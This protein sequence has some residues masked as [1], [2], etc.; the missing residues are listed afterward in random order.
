MNDPSPSKTNVII[1]EV[2]QCL[3]WFRTKHADAQTGI[4][5]GVEKNKI[6]ENKKNKNK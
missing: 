4:I 1:C 2:C 6:W 3:W 5:Y